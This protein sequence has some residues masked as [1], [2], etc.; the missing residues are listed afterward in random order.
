MLI[1]SNIESCTLWPLL[2]ITKQKIT[3]Y[4]YAFF[5]HKSKDLV[6]IYL[7]VR[8]VLKMSIVCINHLI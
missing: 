3:R 6:V 8:N 7:I 4:S 5:L 1:N 2:C